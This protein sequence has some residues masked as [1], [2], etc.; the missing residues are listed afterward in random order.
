VIYGNPV[1]I[2]GEVQTGTDSDAVDY[3][4]YDFQTRS[5][6]FFQNTF[7]KQERNS[8]RDYVPLGTYRFLCIKSI[9]LDLSIIIEIDISNDT[10]R[11]VDFDN[12]NHHLAKLK[13]NRGNLMNFI[14]TEEIGYIFRANRFVFCSWE[15]P[16]LEMQGCLTPKL[17]RM[18]YSEV[19]SHVEKSRAT[20]RY[21]YDALGRRTESQDAG[22]S[23][24]RM[25]Y[26]GFSFEVIREGETFSDGSFTTRYSEG[27]QW[28]NN[29]GTEGSRYRW[30]GEGT[31]SVKTRSLY[32]DGYGAGPGRFT[33]TSVTLYGRGEAVA[34]SRSA[35]TGSRGG[36]A[37]LGKD[38]L[39]S[40]RSTTNEYGSL[41]DRYEYDAF[42]KP[43]TGDLTSGMNLGYTGKPYDTATGLYNY[44]YR[45]YKPEVARFTTIDP[46]RDGANWFA[47][48][49]NDP[50]NWVDPFGLNASDAQT[51]RTDN[52]PISPQ[53]PTDPNNYHC[54]ISA[55][56]EA[57]NHGTDPR[58]PQGVWD[59][60]SVTVSQIY[61]LYTDRHDTPPTG[62][63]GYAFYDSP[64]DNDDISEHMEYYD[65]R[66]GGNTYTL[67]ATDGINEPA[68]Q[69]RNPNDPNRTFVPLPGR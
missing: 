34:V 55:W 50:V 7:L 18:I 26:D 28:T 1:R 3:F 23:P 36:A 21:A 54:D 2:L 29:S 16:D 11:T 10:Y 49:N 60:N 38:I 20:S 27:I 30:I 39:G 25:L 63:A 68:P 67:Y 57:L 40:V 53:T 51:A 9:K 44:G 62:T 31:E 19:T 45:D 58:S 43:Y 32:E 33:G 13:R 24:M 17:N 6:E 15:Y 66:N 41:E 37:Y 47:Y 56:N 59:G 48:V 12:F 35:S 64:D 69:Q 61:D 5:I 8:F 52:T 65:N 22:G 42:G 14:V 4:I 46:V